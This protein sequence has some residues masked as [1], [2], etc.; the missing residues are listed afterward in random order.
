VIAKAVEKD[1]VK[2]SIPKSDDV[3]NLI[4]HSIKSN[5]LFRACTHDELADLV[6]VFRLEEFPCGST[7]IKQGDD[8]D[9]FFVVESGTL[10]ITV[11]SSDYSEVHLG[12]TYGRGSSFGELALMYG[13]PRAATIRTKEDCRLWCIDRNTFRS[14]TGQH[15]IRR[16][17]K[18]IEFLRDV[19][20][21]GKVL[22]DVLDASQIDAMALALQKDS[23]SKG[24]VIVREGEKGDIFYL[25]ESGSVN[26]F[27]ASA[28]KDPITT[29]QSGQFFGERALLSEDVRQATCTAASDVECM[30]LMREDFVMM[31]GDLQDLLDGSE[32]NKKIQAQEKSPQ[33]ASQLQSYVTFLY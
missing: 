26:V 16:A 4:F 22:R 7:V 24:D 18:Q 14:I 8:G 17:E 10:D 20:I 31:L 29:L 9:L 1:F 33:S 32:A 2:Q 30:F 6:D 12:I 21:G 13:S 28:G 23:F 27:K 5:T 19:Q 25:I 15:K 3:C 11:S